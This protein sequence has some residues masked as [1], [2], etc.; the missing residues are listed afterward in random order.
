MNTDPEILYCMC[1]GGLVSAGV[2]C[3]FGD[4]VSERSRGFRLI[5]T[6][7]RVALLLR[8]LVLKGE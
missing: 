4:P 6:S 1:D 2:C 5:K 7:Y 3:V 8:I